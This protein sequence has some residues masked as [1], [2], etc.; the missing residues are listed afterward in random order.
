[1][2]MTDCAAVP[3]DDAHLRT[4]F[5]YKRLSN[6]YAIYFDNICVTLTLF[7][8]IVIGMFLET[9]VQTWKFLS[10]L[11]TYIPLGH[12]S[13]QILKGNRNM[14][15]P[16]PYT[17]SICRPPPQKNLELCMVSA[18]STMLNHPHILINCV[19]LSINY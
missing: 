5:L 9:I 2:H 12:F 10:T 8:S 3:N 19:F 15:R 7:L 16:S 14:F 18:A 13:G 4:M 6:M 11:K 1:M 17:F